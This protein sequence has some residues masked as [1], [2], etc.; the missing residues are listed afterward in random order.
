MAKLLSAT[1]NAFPLERKKSVQQPNTHSFKNYQ[2]STTE[3]NAAVFQT[4]A[5]LDINMITLEN[6]QL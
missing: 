6:V 2:K 1:L 5:L 3:T 4:W